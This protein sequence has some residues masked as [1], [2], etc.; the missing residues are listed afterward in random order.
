M[1]GMELVPEM[2]IFNQLTQPIAQGDFIN[3]GDINS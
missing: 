1:M 3:G 2:L